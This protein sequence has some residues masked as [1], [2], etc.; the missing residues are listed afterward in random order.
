MSVTAVRTPAEYESQLRR[1]LYDRSEEGRAVRVGEKEVS[2]RAEIVAR[3]RDLFSRDQLDALRAAEQEAAD[4]NDRE[5][6]Y[7]LRK[8]CEA[9]VVSAELAEREDA[10]ENAILAARVEFE[11][12]ELPIRSAQA[13]LAVLPDYGEREELGEA[14]GDRSAEFNAERLDVLRAAEELEA[15]ISGEP[16][17]VARNE[18]EKGISLRELEAVLAQASERSTGPYV[19]LRDR[20]FERLLGPDRAKVPSSYHVAYLRRLSPLESTY[21]KDRAVEVCMDTVKRLGFDLENEPNIRLDLD[22]RPQKSPRACVIPSDPP[23]VVHLITRAQGGLHDYQAFLHEAGHAL[24]YAGVDPNLPY[25][26]RNISRDHALTEIYSYIFEAITREPEWHAEYFGLSDEEAA[27]NAEATSFLEAVLFRRYTAKLQ[28]ELDFWS[29]FNENGG[30]PDG[31]EER[32]TEATGVRY[33][34]DAYLADMDGGFY[35]ADYL[36]AWIRSAQLRDYLVREIGQD[37]WRNAETGDSLRALFL[38][39]TRPSSEE[40]A[41]RLGYQPLDT[42]PLSRELGG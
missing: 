42:A 20:W 18:E 10:L 5:R 3:Y 4:D 17:P 16:D 23:S 25:T 9:G 27:R 32:L 38:E 36:R 26:F 14:A 37:W 13:K 39:G 41:A 31:Y 7:R 1:Y 24:H 22:D 2:E 35:S 12:E 28:F 40:I 19:L 6:L 15:E 34:A 29:R 11:G 21:T 33:R 30:G 8:T